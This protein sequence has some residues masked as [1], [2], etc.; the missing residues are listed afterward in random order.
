MTIDVAA[1]RARQAAASSADGDALL[2]LHGIEK[3]WGNR[4]ILAGLDLRVSRGAL[5][6][7]SGANGTGKTTLLRIAAGLI[8]PDS[9]TVAIEGLH[10][11][12]D[13]RPFLRQLGFLSAG[14]RGLYARVTARRHLDLGARLALI[15]SHLRAEAVE[16]ALGVFALEE[17]A[18][19][20][21]DR[22]SMGQRQRVRLAMT[23]VHDPAVILLDEPGNSLDREGLGVLRDYL[24]E[25]RSRGGA[26]VWCAPEGVQTPLAS[27]TTLRLV[28]G[29]LQTA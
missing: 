22:L 25:L 19:R 11:E 12:R 5:V 1:P 24:D 10:P 17:F 18:D 20:R 28:D 2:V 7:I 26:A 16:R 29:N 6:S 23:F 14:D 4:L 9:G 15:P 21:A 8:H 3:R 13:R 27:D